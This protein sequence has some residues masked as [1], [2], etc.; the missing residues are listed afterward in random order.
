LACSA[1]A[2]VTA[3]LPN[4]RKNIEDAIRKY[5]SAALVFTELRNFR[6]SNLCKQLAQLLRDILANKA[7]HVKKTLLYLSY[8]KIELSANEWDRLRSMI[9]L[10]QILDWVNATTILSND[11]TEMPARHEDANYEDISAESKLHDL[12]YEI[13][14]LMADCNDILTTKGNEEIFKPT[15]TM[16]G[17][18]AD[19][20][21]PVRNEADFRNLID[22]LYKVVYEGSAHLARIPERLRPDDSICFTIKHLRT[23]LFHDSDHGDKKD[24]AMK[25]SRLGEIYKRYTGKVTLSSLKPEDF[26]G[27][28]S[29][30]LMELRTFLEDL[31]KHCIRTEFISSVARASPT[32]MRF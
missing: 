1:D 15:S 17:K 3:P 25:K 11:I 29:N 27:F 16:I 30:I 23:G 31:I 2:I 12:G 32:D 20:G 19:V 9:M 21:K 28:Q 10:T 13:V 4:T 14:K 7:E 24:I 5:E 6:S 22:A 26:P 8:G 18:L